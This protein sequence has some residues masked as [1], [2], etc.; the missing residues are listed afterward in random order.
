MFVHSE[1]QL[2]GQQLPRESSSHGE[3]RRRAN[4]FLPSACVVSPNIPLAEVSHLSKFKIK[5]QGDK[6][7]LFVRGTA[8]HHSN[9]YSY[10]GV[11]DWGDNS[12]HHTDVP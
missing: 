3:G 9:G 6:L 4:T 8:K 12:V 7:H 1:L 10:R 11:K 5:G 2:K